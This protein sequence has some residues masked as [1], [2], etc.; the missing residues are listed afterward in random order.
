VEFAE[1][2]KNQPTLDALMLLTLA[3][4]QGTSA[5]AWSDWKESLVWQLYHV[6]SRY[7]GDARNFH[8]QANIQRGALETA[9]GHQLSADYSAE[10]EAHFD[11]MPDNYFR[12]FYIE[13]IAAHIQLFRTFLQKLFCS[14]EAPLAAAIQWEP[15]PEQGHT[16]VSF[17]GWDAQQ[18]LAKIAGSFAVVPVNILSAD[19]YPRGD[20]LVLDV[21]RI[22]D[23]RNHA[24][25]DRRDH[26][27]VEMTLRHALAT[28]EFDFRPLLER[29]RRKIPKQQTR[30][31]EFP[32]RISVD[33][34]A[35][36]AYTLVQIE[37]ADRVGLLYDLL[38]A[39]GRER[40]S[41]ALSRIITEKGAAVD[42]FYVVDQLT[43][44][45]IT[46]AER[47]AALQQ[48]LRDAA[49]STL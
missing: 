10:I 16:I 30:D 21:F 48:A 24:V 19:I 49:T 17:A 20:N 27:L 35:H 1:I 26:D 36:R 2:V 15:F 43:R 37:A 3:D 13:R 42:T 12:A 29:A 33:N 45:K 34:K 41:I 9:V 47:I 4:G 39:F 32:T 6:T 40:I 14:D 22:C 38:T 8:E 7:L 23:I 46:D 25:I 28:E 5:E 11:F 18:L 44:T 31:I